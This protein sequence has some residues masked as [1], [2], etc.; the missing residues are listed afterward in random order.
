[1]SIYGPNIAQVSSRYYWALGDGVTGMLKN[2]SVA[3]KHV[4]ASLQESGIVLKRQGK[5]G[6]PKN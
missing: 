4:D 3:L 2:M 5:R 6:F 1:M